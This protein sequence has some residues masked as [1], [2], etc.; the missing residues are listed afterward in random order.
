MIVSNGIYPSGQ[1]STFH[2]KYFLMLDFLGISSFIH[3][4]VKKTLLK[5]EHKFI[6]IYDISSKSICLRSRKYVSSKIFF[7]VGLSG[8]L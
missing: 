5:G 6:E 2:I 1:E 7:H 8:D 3:N 4:I